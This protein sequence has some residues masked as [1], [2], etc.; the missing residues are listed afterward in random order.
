MFLLTFHADLLLRI[1]SDNPITT[2]EP[3]A[4]YLSHYFQV[5]V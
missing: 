3:E 5:Q 4:F 1:L 2:I